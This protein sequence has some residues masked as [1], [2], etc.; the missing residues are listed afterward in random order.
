ML[1]VAEPPSTFFEKMLVDALRFLF[2]KNGS[3]NERLKSD[4]VPDK[5]A[6]KPTDLPVPR[7]FFSFKFNE[8]EDLSMLE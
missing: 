3:A 8:T 4:L 2:R 7:K 6:E 5:D 1:V